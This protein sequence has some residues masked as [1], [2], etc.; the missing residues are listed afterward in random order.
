MENKKQVP[1]INYQIK[2]EEILKEEQKNDRIPKLLLHSCCAPCSTYVLEYLTQ[3]FDID[4]LYYNPN[5]HPSEE[6][7]KREAEQEKFINMVTKV[8]EIN[9]IK[10]PYNPKKDYFPKVKGYELEPEG[11]LRCNICFELRLDMAAQY[12]KSR[13]YDYFTTTLSLS[14]HKNAQIINEIGEKLEQEYDV[15]YLYA[16]FKKKN[17]FKRSLELCEQYDVYRQDYCGCVFSL[18][19][20]QDRKKA[21]LMEQEELDKALKEDLK[22]VN[23]PKE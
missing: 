9:L 2:L 7:F 23:A 6:Y 17:G 5:I 11:G 10:A 13:G 14:P 19:E 21:K 22:G 8:N 18:K 15:K 4:V 3:H 1:K 12:A 20:S 16:D